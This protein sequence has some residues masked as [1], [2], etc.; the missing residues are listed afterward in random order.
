MQSTDAGHTWSPTLG[1][2]APTDVSNDNQITGL[3]NGIGISGNTVALAYLSDC[4]TGQ[5]GAF[6]QHWVRRLWND[7]VS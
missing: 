5:Q 3:S 1:T 2:S 7:G 6:P 4:V